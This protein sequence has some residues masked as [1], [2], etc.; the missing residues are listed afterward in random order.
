V[1]TAALTPPDR[2]GKVKRGKGKKGPI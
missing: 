2:S 1:C